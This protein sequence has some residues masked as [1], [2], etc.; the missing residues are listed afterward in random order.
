MEKKINKQKKHEH[1]TLEELTK[2]SL[3]DLNMSLK[4]YNISKGEIDYSNDDIDEL[5]EHFNEK[6]LFN[7]S[8][9]IENFK[10]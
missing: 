3:K 5:I 4:R 7:I 10:K 6:G 2:R 1:E 8:K 9:N